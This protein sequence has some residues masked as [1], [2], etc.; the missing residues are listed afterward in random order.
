MN[1]YSQV[2]IID[3]L[4]ISDDDLRRMKAGQTTET[5]ETLTWLADNTAMTL[6]ALS[7]TSLLDRDTHAAVSET[8]LDEMIARTRFEAVTLENIM[9]SSKN[10][11]SATSLDSVNQA[12]SSSIS[13]I[14]SSISPGSSSTVPGATD[15]GDYSSS[16]SPVTRA[17]AGLLLV[18]SDGG[19]RVRELRRLWDV[20]IVEEGAG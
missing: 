8:A 20:E 17:V 13:K 19:L 4:S 16:R 2:V 6:A 9:R 1:P 15:W 10:I 7:S 12:Q 3:E 14:Q 11:A 18:I 5:E